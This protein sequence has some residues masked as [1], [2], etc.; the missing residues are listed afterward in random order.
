[1]HAIA[2][3]IDKRLQRE[4]TAFFLA[5]VAPRRARLKVR[6]VVLEGVEQLG[7]RR[8]VRQRDRRNVGA[9]HR[10]LN[11]LGGAKEKAVRLLVERCLRD[12]AIDATRAR[13][14][15]VRHAVALELVENEHDDR[16][17]E[18]GLLAGAAR[19]SARV[20]V[21]VRKKRE[22]EREPRRCR[23]THSIST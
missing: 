18:D 2:E 5:R 12:G 9:A 22:R 13:R 7:A 10:P 11:G 17:V 21:C 15:N 1:V 4:S 19:D 23:G 16:D 14:V 3:A 8:A 20:R 6:R